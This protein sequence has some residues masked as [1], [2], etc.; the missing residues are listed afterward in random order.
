MFLASHICCVSSGTVRERYTWDS[1]DVK[2]AN[3]TIKKC[4]RGNGIRLTASLRKSEFNCPG[5]RRQHVHPLIVADIKWLRSPTAPKI[6]CNVNE[7]IPKIRWSLLNKSYLSE[8]VC[9]SKSKFI[10]N[11]LKPGISVNYKQEV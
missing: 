4:K 6:K 9:I 5:N 3:P 10:S 2:G 7:S 11:P 8:S 1:L